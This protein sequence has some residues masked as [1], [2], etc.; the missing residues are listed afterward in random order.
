MESWQNSEQEMQM[1]RTANVYQKE[2]GDQKVVQGKREGRER[3]REK[4]IKMY[5]V[6]VSVSHKEFE[7]CFL[8]MHQ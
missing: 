8:H 4:I 1:M 3:M 6:C 5:S 7:H 2:K